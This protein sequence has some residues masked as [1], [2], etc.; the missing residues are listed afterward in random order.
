[1]TLRFVAVPI[2]GIGW[3]IYS[4]WS[5]V[6][7]PTRRSPWIVALNGGNAVVII[8]DLL[9]RRRRAPQIAG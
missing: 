7:R 8:I 1:V 3:V 4:A 5:P 9:R 6:A 2:L